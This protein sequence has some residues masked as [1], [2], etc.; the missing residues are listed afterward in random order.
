MWPHVLW[1]C[2][3]GVCGKAEVI[4]VG[5]CGEEAAHLVRVRRQRYSQGLQ[6]N[7]ALQIYPS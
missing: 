1:A 3:A 7:H 5:A 4:T 2:F 6:A